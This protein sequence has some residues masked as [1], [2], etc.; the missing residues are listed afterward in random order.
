[1]TGGVRP[2]VIDG[3]AV[4]TVDGT[5]DG[6]LAPPVAEP[7]GPEGGPVGVEY[8][9]GH[10]VLDGGRI[11]AVGPGP[12]P[13]IED[14]QFVDGTGCLATPGLI[15]AHQHL[16]QRLTR[17]AAPQGTLA[18]WLAAQYPVWSH[19]NPDLTGVAARSGLAAL[20]LSGCTMV[21]DHHYL[22]PRDGGDLLAAVVAAARDIGLR[23]HC[24][25]GSLDLGVSAGGLPPDSIV[26]DRDEILAATERDIDRFHDPGPDS[27][28]RVAVAPS[29]PVAVSEELL[30]ESAGLARRKGVRLHTHAAESDDED[31]SCRARCGRSLVEYL[32]SADWLG[33]DVWL[34]HAV[35]L[36]AVAVTRMG[37]TSTGVAHCPSSNARLGAGIAPVAGLIAS[38]APVGLGTDGA[39][40]EHGELA[41]ELHQA[42]L[43]ARVRGGPAAL[44]ARQALA[45]GTMGSAR[46]LGRSAELG[47]LEVGKQA[48]VA[49]WRLDGLGHADMADPVGALVF[50]PPA[51]LELLTVAGV[52]VVS[53]GELRTADPATLAAQA[54]AGAADLRRRAAVPLP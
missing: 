31:A 23:L 38:G 47:S 22:F 32:D 1:M 20:A 10:L 17:G 18:D 39:A 50:G 25:R 44:T 45:L 42:L 16:F 29:A 5:I 48:D 13:A 46:C 4:A 49:L 51:P 7:A 26:A 15:A 54:H 36:D 33:P 37:Q 2:L 14:A 27:M 40:N 53:G 8:P 19:L 21:A 52:P 30:R 35:H 11:T 12:A 28:L 41:A 3:C 24:A 6:V 43:A 9:R 34:A